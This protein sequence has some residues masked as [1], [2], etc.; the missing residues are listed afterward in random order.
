MLVWGDCHVSGDISEVVTTTGRCS[1]QKNL[2]FDEERLISF[3]KLIIQQTNPL[4]VDSLLLTKGLT[5]KIPPP[6]IKK[7]SK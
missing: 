5:Y 3:N 4:E 1:G 7:K 2:G 6:I